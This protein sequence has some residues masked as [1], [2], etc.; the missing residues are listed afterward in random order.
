MMLAGT[1]G[2][3][4]VRWKLIW[5]CVVCAGCT[6]IRGVPGNRDAAV[7]DADARSSDAATNMALGDA[8]TPQ[9]DAG[10]VA[11]DAIQ[12][13][14]APCA[15]AGARACSERASTLP[16]VCDGVSWIPQTSCPADQRCDTNSGPNEGVCQPIATECV[17][18]QPGVAFCDGEQ[19][20]V[21]PDLLSSEVHA[22]PNGKSC[23][24]QG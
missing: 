11:A 10:T 21:S 15:D 18:R 1:R 23:M 12:T 20:R 14:K 5:A 3:L 24:M 7:L 4:E 8:S 22:C 16:L 9:S 6:P 2:A 13:P 17:D 19:L